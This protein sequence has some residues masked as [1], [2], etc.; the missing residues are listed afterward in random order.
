MHVAGTFRA[1]N[2][3]TAPLRK[4]KLASDAAASARLMAEGLTMP[5]AAGRR[6]G[7]GTVDVWSICSPSG[8]GTAA[9]ASTGVRAPVSATVEAMDDPT[10]LRAEVDGREATAE[11]LRFPAFAYGH[12]TAMQIRGRSVRGL[13][14]HLSRLDAANRELFGAGLGRRPGPRSDPARAR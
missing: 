12:F 5:A 1:S 10:I 6:C 13:E 3:R 7:A 14:L 11:Q 2:V 8:G 4:T 9:D